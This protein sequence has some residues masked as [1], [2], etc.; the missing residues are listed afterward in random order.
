MSAPAYPDATPARRHGAAELVLLAALVATALMAGLFWTWDISVM[1]GLARLDD[2]TFVTT[3]QAL[4]AA[5][6]NGGVSLALGGALVLTA[7]AAVTEHRRGRRSAA[8]WIGAALA[9]YL[10]ALVVT[11]AVHLPLNAAISAVDAG[12]PAPVLTG[13]RAAFEGPWRAANPLRTVLCVVA[14]ACL[15]RTLALPRR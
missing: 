11:G 1:P 8:R 4:D 12:A 7:V 15:G 9:L 10:A 6:D 2:R 5:I 3:M 13:A 14:V